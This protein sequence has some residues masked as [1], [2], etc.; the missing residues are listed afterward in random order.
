MEYPTTFSLIWTPNKTEE[1]S[2][3]KSGLKWRKE[4]KDLKILEEAEKLGKH[5]E[6]LLSFFFFFDKIIM[7]SCIMES[8]KYICGSGILQLIVALL[9]TYDFNA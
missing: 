8:I 1:T 7:F 3:A 2:Q 9:F 5:R 4:L 6:G